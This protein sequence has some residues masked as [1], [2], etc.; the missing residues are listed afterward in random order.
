M[1][2]LV[3]R[4]IFVAL[5]FD[6]WRRS[7]W[8]FLRSVRRE[9]KS[10]Y[11]TKW[12]MF[13]EIFQL[14]KSNQ[15]SFDNTLAFSLFAGFARRPKIQPQLW[16]LDP[17]HQIKQYFPPLSELSSVCDPWW[18]STKS[19]VM[20]FYLNSIHKQISLSQWVVNVMFCILTLGI[21]LNNSHA[22]DSTGSRSW[23][24]KRQNWKNSDRYFRISDQF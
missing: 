13:Q 7:V 19:G 16:G 20:S 4:T 1:S 9:K 10:W 11:V 17:E 24:I 6:H 2:Y 5:F 3:A 8:T 23:R 18:Q 22:Q 21:S 15:E 14:C 12:T